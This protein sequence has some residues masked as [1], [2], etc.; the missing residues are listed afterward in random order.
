MKIQERRLSILVFGLL[1]IGCY[2]PPDPSHLK[3][4]IASADRVEILVRYDGSAHRTDVSNR[5]TLVRLSQLLDFEGPPRRKD[6][7]GAVATNLF[8]DVV[9]VRKDRRRENITVVGGG[10]IWYGPEN[11]YY[12]TLSNTRF[13]EAILQLAGWTPPSQ[14][15]SDYVSNTP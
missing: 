8:I 2:S 5:E 14:E 10:G 3:T 13:T 4:A 6:P 12:I 1:M 11:E 9:V 15:Q 7:S